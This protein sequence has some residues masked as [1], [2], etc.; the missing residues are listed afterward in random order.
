MTT[1]VGWLIDGDMF[2]HYRDELVAAVKSQGHTAKLIHAP[3]PPFRWDDVGCSY[4]ETF[5]ADLCVVAHGDIALVAKIQE[6]QRWKPGVF[7]TTENYFCSKYAIHFGEFWLNRDY[8]MLPFGELNRRKQF[9]IDTLGVGGNIFVRPDSPLKLFTG[10]TASAETFEADVEY[11]GFY[12]FPHDSMVVVSTPKSIRREWR[13]VATDREIVAGCLYCKNG[14]FDPKAEVDHNAQKLANTI[15]SHPWSPDPVWIIDV[16]E[17]ADGDY[18]LLEIGGFSFA[19]LY[20]CDK[21]AVVEAVSS[22]ATAEW[23]ACKES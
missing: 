23:R 9:L 4:R 11:M 15:A 10:Q 7:A 17:T 1:N 19:D 6:E 14:D 12:E 8:L 2:P 5:P 21:P 16:C 20:V 3:N 18:H 13:F 22:A